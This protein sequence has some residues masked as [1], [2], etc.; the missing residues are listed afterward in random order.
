MVG[1]KCF[2]VKEEEKEVELSENSETILHSFSPLPLLY[3]AALLPGGTLILSLLNNFQL[4][5]LN[6]QIWHC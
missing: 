4:D 5:F 3:A 6:T 2:V 1:H